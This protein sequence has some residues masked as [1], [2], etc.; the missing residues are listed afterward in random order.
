[1]TGS[2]ETRGEVIFIQQ[3]STRNLNQIC[4]ALSIKSE[5]AFQNSVAHSRL[6]PP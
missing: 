5:T 1:M 3:D 2:H 4:I 6:T